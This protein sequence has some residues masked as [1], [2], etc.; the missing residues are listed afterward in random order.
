VLV[1]KDRQRLEEFVVDRHSSPESAAVF[2]GSAQLFSTIASYSEESNSKKY[3]QENQFFL[4]L[5]IFFDKKHFTLEK[6]A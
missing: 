1:T 6:R 3:I 5:K 2:F 4:L